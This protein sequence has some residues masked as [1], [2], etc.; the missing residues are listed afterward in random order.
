[1]SIL[2]KSIVP[3][4]LAFTVLFS[5]AGFGADPSVN[6]GKGIQD[7]ANGDLESAEAALHKAKFTTPDDPRI[8][9]DLG[10][11]LY[12]KRQYDTSIR[13]FESCAKNS[14]EDSL[15][16][17]ALHNLGNAAYRQ[18]RYQEAVSAFQSSLDLHEDPLTRFN[19]EQA[20]KK[21]K[22]EMERRKQEK[23][24]QEK[25]KQNQQQGND[26]QKS[27]QKQ[28]GQKNDQKGSDGKGSPQD[29]KQSQ[30]SDGKDQGQNQNKQDGKS[31]D[32]KPGE[33]QKQDQS[34]PRDD[35]TAKNASGTQSQQPGMATDSVE[36]REEPRQ[37][38]SM[39]QPGKETAPPPDISQKARALKNIKLNPYAVEKLLKDLEEREKEI[40]QRYRRENQR[41]DQ[42]DDE[43]DP[44]FMS[45]SQLRDFMER[46]NGPRPQPKSETPDW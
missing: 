43:M 35:K 33:S 24:K 44:F 42:L 38:V 41:D 6:V 39:A 17:D 18:A 13:A 32:P 19:L 46:R 8:D 15:R 26:Q 27:D 36:P 10:I 28:D 30:K 7:L 4:V 23:Q 21:L 31:G 1:M 25:Q 34:Q 9:Y 45:P 37:D 20:K 14:P 12:K 16:G 22:E 29:Q 11:V 40:Q 5:A 3:L 2:S